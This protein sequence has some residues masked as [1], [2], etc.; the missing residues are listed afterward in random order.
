VT[1]SPLPTWARIGIGVLVEAGFLSYVIRYGRRAVAAG[2]TGDLA[3]GL[4]EDVAP[5]A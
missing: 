3:V 1:P 5:V 4:R 2:E